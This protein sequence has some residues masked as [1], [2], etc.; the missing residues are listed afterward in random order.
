[1]YSLVFFQAESHFIVSCSYFLLLCRSLCIISLS[2][3]G[4]ATFFRPGSLANGLN[5]SLQPVPSFL[6]FPTCNEWSQFSRTLPSLG[7]SPCPPSRSRAVPMTVFLCNMNGQIIPV[8]GAGRASCASAVG[9]CPPRWPTWHKIS[10][11]GSHVGSPHAN[12]HHSVAALHQLNAS[13]VSPSAV[14]PGGEG[15]DLSLYLENLSTVA[16]GLNPWLSALHLSPSPAPPRWPL[17]KVFSVPRVFSISCL[18]PH[19]LCIPQ[20]HRA[21]A[22]AELDFSQGQLCWM[23]APGAAG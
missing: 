4:F 20:G 15:P 7:G 22:A 21:A 5:K 18:P 6:P 16:L 14:S 8:T 10:V 11:W 13:S 12:Q 19:Q 1:M 17:H 3:V 9:R 23:G 2:S